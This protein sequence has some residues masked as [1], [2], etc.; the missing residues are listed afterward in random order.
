MC[1]V[2]LDHSIVKLH[3]MFISSSAPRILDA[4]RSGVWLIFTDACFDPEAFSTPEAFSG[5][6]AV[7]LSAA[8]ESYSDTFHRIFMWNSSR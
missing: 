8:K 7:Y 1:G 4:A 3:R 5:V 6:G 2:D